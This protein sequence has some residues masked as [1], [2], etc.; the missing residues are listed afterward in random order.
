M[1]LDS[2]VLLWALAGDPRL[3][4]RATE[5]MLGATAVHASS[6]TFLELGMKQ[7][8]G[9]LTL[10]PDFAR[11]VAEQGERHA[12]FT[13]DDAAQLGS[14]PASLARH[15]PFDRALLAQA[16]CRGWEFV[17]ADERL[18]ALG[19]GWVRDGRV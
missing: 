5:A 7:S 1:L 10:P 4:P 3:G 9:K 14:L 2:Q 8:L 6:I 15:D 12:P 11:L 19:L 16:K 17:T 18:L 13:A